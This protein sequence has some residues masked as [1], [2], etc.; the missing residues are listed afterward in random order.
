MGVRE[1]T[2]GVSLYDK[3]IPLTIKEVL[4]S[5]ISEFMHD[6]FGREHPVEKMDLRELSYVEAG[7]HIDL[8][9]KRLSRAILAIRAL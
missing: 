5:W 1:C 6:R 9:G 2:F 7:D 3:Q 4:S 8:L